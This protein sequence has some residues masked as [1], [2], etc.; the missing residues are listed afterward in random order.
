MGKAGVGTAECAGLE[1]DHIDFQN[2]RITLYRHKTDTGY[3]ITIFPQLRELLGRLQGQGRVLNG[4]PVF[5]VRDPKKA[6]DAACKRLKLPHFSP[7]SLRRGF[8]TR[9]I[10]K[11]VD[12][13]TIASWQGHRDGGVPRTI[14][15]RPCG[16]VLPGA[17]CRE[18]CPLPL[19]VFFGPP[20]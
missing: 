4:L 6:L 13:K 20:L 16:L 2:K 11:G 12:F 3:A 1:G 18:L 7:R 8:I 17:E 15:V 5:K 10:E 9:A 14:A 19:S